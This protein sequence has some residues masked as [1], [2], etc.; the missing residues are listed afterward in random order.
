MICTRFSFLSLTCSASLY[1]T[2]GTLM[3]HTSSTWA[4]LPHLQMTNSHKLPAQGSH[5]KVCSQQQKLLVST[6][7]MGRFF[8]LLPKDFPQTC[9]LSTVSAFSC[10]FTHFLLSVA[11]LS[12]RYCNVICLTHVL[13]LKRV[14]FMY[15]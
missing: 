11:H 3:A 14:H 1:D 4:C 13:N 5:L 7:F 9:P 12:F 8:H 2:E 6:A 10:V 15:R